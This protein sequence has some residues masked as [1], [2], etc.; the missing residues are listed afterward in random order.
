MIA[1]ALFVIAAILFLKYWP[2]TEKL[3]AKGISYGLGFL[4]ASIVASPFISWAIIE[5]NAGN[6]WVVWPT[7][8]I[9]AAL[10]VPG[11]ASLGKGRSFWRK[12]G[13][14]VPPKKSGE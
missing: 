4:A 1:F 3:T 12:A 8:L 2:T 5:G 7:Y 9:L 14:I 10:L 6:P 11:I 13:G